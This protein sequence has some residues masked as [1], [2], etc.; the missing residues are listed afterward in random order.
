VR[1]LLRDYKFS[2]Y[3]RIMAG[4]GRRRTDTRAVAYLPSDA[5]I[6]W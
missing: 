2:H 6:A 1:R 5:M 4:D 3:E